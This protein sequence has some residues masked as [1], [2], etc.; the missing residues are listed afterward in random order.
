MVSP[1]ILASGSFLFLTIVSDSLK[2]LTDF[3]TPYI[4]R[5]NSPEDPNF[6]RG[7]LNLS[8]IAMFGKQEQQNSTETDDLKAKLNY[9]AEKE[10]QIMNE[11]RNGNKSKTFSQ[12]FESNLGG[13]YFS[14]SYKKN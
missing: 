10:K 4:N 6:L 7:P 13:E 14:F 9:G 12:L 2:I 11:I 3:A 8:H 5:I 1:P